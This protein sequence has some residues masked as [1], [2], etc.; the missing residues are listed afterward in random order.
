MEAKNSL[1]K[2]SLSS[3]S[4]ANA[5]SS[6]L[7]AGDGETA[8]EA[9]ADSDGDGTVAGCR[10]NNH[11]RRVGNQAVRVENER[12]GF[13]LPAEMAVVPPA[14]GSP[15]VPL[16]VEGPTTEKGGRLRAEIVISDPT[17]GGDASSNNVNGGPSSSSFNLDEF[18]NLACRVIDH[19][20]EAAMDALN[21]LK[22]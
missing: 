18:L 6:S 17:V 19:G 2:N 21:E 3:F 1:S 8:G 15:R 16:G 20:D 5:S 22:N 13:P 7:P 12:S 9:P 11:G 14:E 10:T 4:L